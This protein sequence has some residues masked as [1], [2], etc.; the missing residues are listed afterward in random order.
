M[1]P[2]A[3]AACSPR[4]PGRWELRLGA[5][6]AA[7][8]LEVGP[9]PGDSAGGPGTEEGTRPGKGRRR[10]ELPQPGAGKRLFADHS[11]AFPCADVGTGALQPD[12]QDVS[13]VLSRRPNEARGDSQGPAG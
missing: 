5:S 10:L 4:P 9:G 8:R 2:W 7:A 11:L 6:G 1:A 3:P 12:L 13:K